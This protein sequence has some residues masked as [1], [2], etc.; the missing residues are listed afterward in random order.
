MD[1]LSRIRGYFITYSRIFHYVSM[2]IYIKHPWIQAFWMN[3]GRKKPYRSPERFIVKIAFRLDYRPATNN[4]SSTK[5]TSYA[6]VCTS[7]TL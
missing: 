4:K 6:P 7:Y 5:Y 2:S 1:I 3:R